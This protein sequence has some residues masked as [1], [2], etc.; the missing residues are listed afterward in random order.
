MIFNLLT[1]ARDF[2]CAKQVGYRKTR[3]RK[4]S[5]FMRAGKKQG[6]FRKAEPEEIRKA[7]EIQINIKNFEYRKIYA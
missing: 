3:Q 7:S 2:I 5:Q 4:Y 1:E 6:H